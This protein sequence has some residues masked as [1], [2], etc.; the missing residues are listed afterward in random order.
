MKVN[1][2]FEMT[3][4]GHLGGDGT[5]YRVDKNNAGVDVHQMFLNSQFET[6]GGNGWFESLNS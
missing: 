5:G 4:N 2:N 1:G 3:F 6:N